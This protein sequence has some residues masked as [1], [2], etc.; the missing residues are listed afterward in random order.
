MATINLSV[1]INTWS[2]EIVR[3]GNG[4]EYRHIEVDVMEVNTQYPQQY[5]LQIR[6]DNYAKVNPFLAQNTI[7]TFKCNLQGRNWTNAEGK[8]SNFL[9]LD[10]FDVVA[11]PV[12]NAP[13]PMQPAPQTV[14]QPQATTQPAQAQTASTPAPPAQP[15]QSNEPPF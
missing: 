14:S 10:C 12:Q 8:V 5:K 7:V 9:T 13:Q 6:S 11:Q 3:Q 15:V 4:K 1:M 2:A